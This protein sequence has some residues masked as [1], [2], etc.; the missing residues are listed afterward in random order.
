ME[1][2]IDSADGASNVVARVS[3]TES[4]RSGGT[5]GSNYH[6]RKTMRDHQESSLE[7]DGSDLHD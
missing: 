4:V 6:N 3:S 1:E 7:D 5:Y 2:K